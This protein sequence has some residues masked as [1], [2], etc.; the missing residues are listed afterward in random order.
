MAQITGMR[1]NSYN[2]RDATLISPFLGQI[3]SPVGQVMWKA[4][5]IGFKNSPLGSL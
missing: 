5:S 4:P 1:L 3:T 2:S